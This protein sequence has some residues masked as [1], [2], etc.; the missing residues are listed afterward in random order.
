MAITEQELG[1][2]LDYRQ[3]FSRYANVTGN[4]DN[5]VVQCCI[6][7]HDDTGAS[8]SLDMT[9]GLWFCHGQCPSNEGR[10]R[11]GNVYGFVM[12]MEG[13]THAEA[14]ERLGKE[15][16]EE[17]ADVLEDIG[18]QQR[19]EDYRLRLWDEKKPATAGLRGHLMKRRGWTEDTLRQWQIGWDG[20]RYTFPILDEHGDVANI[21][22]YKP[23]PKD[24]EEKWMSIAKHGKPR[25]YAIETLERQSEIILV[26]GET[27]MVTAQQYGI[28]GAIT[29]T[30][31]SGQ[32]NQQWNDQFVGKTV[33]I[34]YDVDEAG[35]E[36]TKLVGMNLTDV[37]HAVYDV[38]LPLDRKKFPAG[39]LSDYLATL[40][41]SIEDCHT[42]FY[43]V[44]NGSKVFV[45]TG[46]EDLSWAQVNCPAPFEVDDQSVLRH[47]VKSNSVE[48]KRV[49]TAPAWISGYGWDPEEQQAYLNVVYRSERG[50]E[51]RLMARDDVM[52]RT[53]LLRQAQYGLPVNSQNA[54]AMAEYFDHFQSANT[55]LLPETHVTNR[56][57]WRG[58]D[59]AE[60]QDWE[61]KMFVVGDQAFGEKTEVSQAAGDEA[62]RTFK[63][64]GS[65]DAWMKIMQEAYDASTIG[66]LYLYAAFAGPLLRPL[67]VRSGILHNY[68]TTRSGKTAFLKLTASVWGNPLAML[69][70]MNTTQ[71]F[72]ERSL[73]QFSDLPYC[74]DELQLNPHEDFLN[75][76]VY[77][78][79]QERGKGRGKREGGVH[80]T[81]TWKSVA[82]ITGEQ[83]LV[84]SKN[85]GGQDTRV[86]E[87]PGSPSPNEDLAQR[88]HRAVERNFGH[89]GPLFLNHLLRTPL[90]EIRETMA[91][92][93]VRVRQA[94]A[95]Q[96]VG[97]TLGFTA[98]ILT[99]GY[100]F[101]KWIRKVTMTVDEVVDGV[102]EAFREVKQADRYVIRAY[103]WLRQLPLQNRRHFE[104]KGCERVYEGVLESFNSRKKWH[105]APNQEC[106]GR[107]PY[108]DD[109]GTIRDEV[110]FIKA[111]LERQCERDGYNYEVLRRE[112]LALGL[113]LGKGKSENI[114]GTG[115]HTLRFKWLTD[116]E[117]EEM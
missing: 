28:K 115:R 39:D 57:G 104:E 69:N 94:F 26:E 117:M 4:R 31:G 111:A 12:R 86:L 18:L 92:I 87:V 78:I 107:L 15:V 34:V 65:I 72:I 80:E 50:I 88:L 30:G 1:D 76:I 33:Y 48:R 53:R 55:D 47:V 108:V 84:S 40:E 7:G 46:S 60:S 114:A 9:S 20:Y 85:L 52:D 93:E 91:A 113:L 16:G 102:V 112:C 79:A 51:S 67:Q 81:L 74:L 27:D 41:G 23:Q 37:A 11:G 54:T 19:A 96:L 83:P 105:L 73:H 59:F 97:S 45:P 17:I 56:N 103:D 25:L 49:N 43:K 110:W 10:R 8:L 5:V 13:C 71:V 32:W 21:R 75:R 95:G 90:D 24:D 2:R 38:R 100:Y 89:A 116:D 61:G 106:W 3:I 98:L 22:R 109:D 64:R 6:P 36:G 29:S 62:T 82:M 42:E 99:A 35:R 14:V 66:R 44:L 68:A 101:E 58:E 70:S 77:M 63:A